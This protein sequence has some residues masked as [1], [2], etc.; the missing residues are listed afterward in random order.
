LIKTFFSWSWLLNTRESLST[1]QYSH[2]LNNTNFSP[3]AIAKS[4]H[5]AIQHLCE[6]TDV[7]VHPNTGVAFLQGLLISMQPGEGGS[8]K[9]FDKQTI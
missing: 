8:S 6:Q 2:S 3:T 5:S 7:S 4:K 1:S 9:G